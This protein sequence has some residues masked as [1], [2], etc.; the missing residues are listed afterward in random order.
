ML[1]D[2]FKSLPALDSGVSVAK[3]HGGNG[4]RVTASRKPRRAHTKM[5][6]QPTTYTSTPSAPS[7]Q[8]GYSVECVVAQSRCAWEHAQE[9]KILNERS[10][11]DIP[12]LW[13]PRTV[14]F[15]YI[16]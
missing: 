14:I 15:N 16:L 12:E 5:Q 7:V 1:V 4:R 11:V 2:A 6:S 13:L 9:S 10:E 8:C 3:T